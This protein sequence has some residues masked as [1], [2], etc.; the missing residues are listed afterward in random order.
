MS[1]VSRDGEAVFSSRA[2]YREGKGD[3]GGESPFSAMRLRA[4]ASRRFQ[5]QVNATCLKDAILAHLLTKADSV[6]YR[7]HRYFSLAE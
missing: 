4:A 5:S 7:S 2:G 3:V 6:S 1:G